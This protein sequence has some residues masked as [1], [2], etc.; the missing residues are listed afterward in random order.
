MI[1]KEVPTLCVL[2]YHYSDGSG[3]EIVRVYSDEHQA[4]Q[5]LELVKM[6][7][8]MKDWKLWDVPAIGFA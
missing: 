8:G 4:R 3:Y 5:D 6:A 1:E 7:D 2:A